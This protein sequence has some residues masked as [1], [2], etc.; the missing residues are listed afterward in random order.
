[1]QS[2]F[3]VTSDGRFSLQVLTPRLALKF[4][5][6]IYNH[7]TRTTPFPTMNGTL[8]FWDRAGNFKADFVLS[9]QSQLQG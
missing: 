2:Q 3:N 5:G 8:Q 6:T 1:V 4:S 7:Q 9:P